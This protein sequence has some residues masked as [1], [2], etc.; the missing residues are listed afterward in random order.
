MA[1]FFLT[2]IMLVIKSRGEEQQAVKVQ[3]PSSL[4]LLSGSHPNKEPA[5][6]M[7]PEHHVH[8]H[9]QKTLNYSPNKQATLYLVSPRS[10]PHVR[11]WAPAH[12]QSC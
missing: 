4:L 12:I 2:R 10:R 3:R 9:I 5:G 8:K 6:C 7:L 1:F 11:S